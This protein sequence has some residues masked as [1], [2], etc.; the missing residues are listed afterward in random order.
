LA[1]VHRR[2]LHRRLDQ[3]VTHEHRVSQFRNRR[4]SF[5]ILEEGGN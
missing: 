1:A 2:H 5:S 3:E 4:V